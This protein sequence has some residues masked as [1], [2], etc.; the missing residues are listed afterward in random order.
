M[1]K[2]SLIYIFIFLSI[3]LNDL[4]PQII[5]DSVSIKNY[6]EI[7][8]SFYVF[9]KLNRPDFDFQGN[10]FQITNS[11]NQLAIKNF[12]N[13]IQQNTDNNSILILFDLA[14]DTNK[15]KLYKKFTNYF[16]DLLSSGSTDISLI[17]FNKYPLINNYFTSDFAKIKQNINSLVNSDLSDVPEA[18]LLTPGGAFDLVKSGTHTNKSIILISEGN[19]IYDNS[20]IVMMANA[21]GIPIYIV[22]INKIVS[23]D[24]ISLYKNTSGNKTD[25]IDD[26]NY[27]DKA[28]IL[29]AEIFKFKPI[30][31]TFDNILS[32]DNVNSI[33]INNTKTGDKTSF[34]IEI[35]DTNKP[36]LEIA[37][38]YLKFGGVLPGNTST[39]SVKLT[40]RKKDI[41]ISNLTLTSNDFA[42]QGYNANDV[43]VIHQ[44]ETKNLDIKYAPT[45]SNLVFA[46]LQINSDACFGK[47]LYISAGFPNKAPKNN[48]IKITN[49]NGGETFISG[50]TAQIS[51][52]GVLPNDIIQL[53][54]STD[55]MKTWDTLA[56]NVNGLKYT[57]QVVPTFGNKNRVK[58]VQLWPNNIGQTL[59]L[60]HQNIVYTANFSKSDDEGHIVTTANDGIV[61]LFKSYSGA[62]IRK[63]V[64][65]DGKEKLNWA[66]FSNDD[67]YISA[68][69]GNGTII[70]WQTDNAVIYKNMNAHNGEVTCVNFNK[71]NTQIV[72]TGTDDMVKIWDVKTGNL[73][74]AFDNGTKVWYCKFIKNDSKILFCDN[75]GKGKVY[76]IASGVIE[77]TFYDDSYRFKVNNVEINKDEDFVAISQ[78]DGKAT[79]Y[80]YN[81]EKKLYSVSHFDTMSIN[82]TVN[83]VDFGFDPNTNEHLIITS[84]ND[85]TAKIWKVTNGSYVKE[86]KEHTNG[87]NMAVFNFDGSRILTSS[88]DSTAKVWNLNKR[89][90]QIDTSD[91]NFTIERA[92][93][94]FDTLRFAKTAVMEIRYNN[95]DKYITN[96]LAGGFTIYDIFVSGNNKDEF[97]ILDNI[98]KFRINPSESK[99]ISMSFAPQNIGV[100]T[101]FLNIIV[102]YS[103]DKK[104]TI[105]IPI[106]GT[107]YEPGLQLLVNTVD[108]GRVQIGDYKDTL[109]SAALKNKTLSDV[110]IKN[111]E[112]LNPSDN[113]FKII[114]NIKNITLK[115]Q[116]ILPLTIRFYSN[117][118]GKKQ[119]VFKIENNKTADVLQLLLFAEGIELDTVAINISLNDVS[120]NIGEEVEVP[121]EFTVNKQNFN[122]NDIIKFE[123][124]YNPKVAEFLDK[125]F[126]ITIIDGNA[127]VDLHYTF[128]E[129]LAKK[130]L[131]FKTGLSARD[132]TDLSIKNTSIV[133]NDKY[134]VSSKDSKIIIK[135]KCVDGNNILAGSK[136]KI[137]IYPNPTARILNINLN[138]ITVPNNSQFIIS[139]INLNV[140]EKFNIDNKTPHSD[141]SIDV[142]NLSVGIYF[143]TLKSDNFTQTI[144]FEILK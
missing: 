116:E 76:D 83:Y 44:G 55:D 108:F 37:P 94:K 115:P 110:V 56:S 70:I 84:S 134:I 71:D 69:Y 112:N 85:Y 97:K 64:Y 103:A 127:N 35:A 61:R 128:E 22:S 82:S 60:P 26:N 100:R 86:L 53:Q 81:T 8:T 52:F 30:E 50:D 122:K 136:P 51:W 117:E 21:S 138:N 73:I 16:I 77:K 12:I 139:D 96:P 6:P 143:L 124:Q 87:V 41:T 72:S 137:N 15:I 45:D 133:S 48:T 18:F 88:I 114:D 40:A 91:A 25:A 92:K 42:I 101:A 67:K 36:Y 111:V 109:V 125:N 129:L 132:F 120:A 11:G 7:G 141:C 54:Y 20:K 107:G 58:I 104:D 14:T 93:L 63:Y 23:N 135:N 102:P 121:I 10:D 19:K 27:Q 123:L 1:L 66:N 34:K 75:K 24:V 5:I 43:I 49:P 74:K 62:V 68:A 29:Y 98:E 31:I 47:D 4:L 33:D 32:C 119:G 79:V 126:K 38:P 99:N 90:L 65:N 144:R 39:L 142:S 105:Q 118:I 59:D 113:N 140:I 80:D 28:K 78:N 95:F 131:K 89:D 9:N 3:G 13:P 106:I 2:K 130:S 46:L 57:W 17:S